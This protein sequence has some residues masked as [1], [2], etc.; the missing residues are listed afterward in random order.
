MECDIR[1][2]GVRQREG[3]N[4]VV[5]QPGVPGTHQWRCAPAR[6]GER[7][8]CGPGVLG[9]LLLGLVALQLPVDRV[10]CRRHTP[11]GSRP[12]SSSCPLLGVFSMVRSHG[13]A[14]LARHR[15]SLSSWSPGTFLVC[16]SSSCPSLGVFSMVRSH[17]VASLARRYS[18]SSWSPGTFLVCLSWGLPDPCLPSL[19]LSL[20]FS[21]LLSWGLLDPC[22]TPSYV[23]LLFLLFF[24]AGCFFP[25]RCS[26][27]WCRPFPPA[28]SSFFP[29]AWMSCVCG[30]SCG[31]LVAG[32]LFPRSC[33]LAC[34][35]RILVDAGVS[36]GFVVLVFLPS[37]PVFQCPELLFCY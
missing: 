2:G 31:F 34:P 24:S 3:E 28:L 14:S 8:G 35:S 32:Y 12:R 36:W 20:L 9:P 18:L 23:F 22:L 13:V 21:I 4:V 29:P 17:G 19:L 27:S 7:S 11:L 6:E 15:Y 30:A 37:L 16:L 5:A 10:C 33:G 26:F 1:F 25:G